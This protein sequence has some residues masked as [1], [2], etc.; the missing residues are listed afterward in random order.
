MRPHRSHVSII[1][2]VVLALFAG[3]C[4]DVPT[5]PGGKMRPDQSARAGK[6]AQRTGRVLPNTVKYSNVGSQA[7]AVT[8]QGVTVSARAYTLKDGMTILTVVAGAFDAAR[9]ALGTLY[10]VPYTVYDPNG[11]SINVARSRGDDRL[12][13]RG[14]ATMSTFGTRRWS[15]ST[16][17]TI[18][19]R[20]TWT[21]CRRQ[22]KCRT[23]P[24]SFSTPDTISTITHYHY[25]DDPVTGYGYHSTYTLDYTQDDA[26]Q[27]A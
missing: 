7:S 13:G 2:A 19:L 6:T 12:W 5:A 10:R 22:W 25:D 8:Y 26:Q 14:T 9:S 18:M 1:A 27:Y 17:Q 23:T 24:R 21:F 15:I 4:S 16:T 3:A 20:S 11:H